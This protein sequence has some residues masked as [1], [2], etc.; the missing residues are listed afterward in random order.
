MKINNAICHVAS[1]LAQPEEQQQQKKY[2]KKCK[3]LKLEVQPLP[4]LLHPQPDAFIME[5]WGEIAGGTKQMCISS[6]SNKLR[7]QGHCRQKLDA[8]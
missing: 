7:Q 5:F 2:K 8:E 6:E 3:R 1:L 4:L